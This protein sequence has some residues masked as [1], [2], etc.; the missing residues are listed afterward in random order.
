[1]K[2]ALIKKILHGPTLFLKSDGSH[3]NKT[4]YLDTTRKLFRL[5]EQEYQEE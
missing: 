3:G 2:H 4:D 1:M 5:D